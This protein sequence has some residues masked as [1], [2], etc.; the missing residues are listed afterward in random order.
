[1]RKAAVFSNKIFAGVLIEENRQN[2]VFRYDEAW[3]RDA[4]K[5]AISLTL[6][7]T[8]QEYRSPYLFPCFFNMLSEG[9]NKELQC[10]H[11]KIDENDHF[12]L[13]VETAQYE[14]IGVITVKSVEND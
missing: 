2:Y 10:R 7:K 3:F 6:P 13:L 8:Q 9:A 4:Q 14:T 5:S 12:S 1:M 11:L